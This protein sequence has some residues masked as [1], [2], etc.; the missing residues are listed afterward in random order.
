[1]LELTAG[2]RAG[3]DINEGTNERGFILLSHSAYRWLCCSVHKITG[4]NMHMSKYDV[5]MALLL[6]VVDLHITGT[7]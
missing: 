7:N 3:S 5:K 2:E 4:Q 6:I 1:M